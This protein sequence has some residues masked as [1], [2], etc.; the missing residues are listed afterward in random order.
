[1]TTD[2]RLF[3]PGP[4]T[5]SATV[6]RA[7]LHDLGSR[8]AAFIQTVS[9]VRRALLALG[10]VSQESGYEAV[11]VQ[12]SGTFGL[13]AMVSSLL[14]DTGKLLVLVN[15]AYGA[16]LVNMA[17]V[18]GVQVESLEHAEDTAPDPDALDRR[19]AADPDIRHVAVVHCETT[20]GILNPVERLGAVTRRH[21]R[22]LLVDAMSSFGALPVDLAGWGVDALVSSSNKCIQG[23]PGFAFVL[24]RTDLLVA[25][26]GRAR[27]MSLDLHAQ[28]K[29]LEA[30]GQ[31]R[32]TPP[33]HVI[34]AFRQALAELAEEGGPDA[35]GARYRANQQ[36][37]VQGMQALGFE[38]Y[39]DAGLQGP[40]IT[41]FREPQHPRFDFET[42]YRH[43][44]AR[45]MVIYPGKLT[46][47]A[48]FR[49]GSIGDLHLADMDELLACVRDVLAEMDIDLGA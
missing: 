41:T 19:L 16:R 42:F 46:E 32:F 43:L 7:M 11:I 48:C 5:T 2:K 33:T 34:L 10:Q 20:T 49:I 21:D 35:R 15:G 44:A 40:I 31:F 24:C 18:H 30:N 13:E 6:K 22:S 25:A 1:M 23:V 27:T 38:A 28:W 45:E 17:R 26:E 9:D 37:L 4:L 29:G 14:P 47:A 3:T 39:L 8:D 36:R 12:G